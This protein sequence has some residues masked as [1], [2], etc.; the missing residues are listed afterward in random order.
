MYS[1]TVTISPNPSPNR[2]N[3]LLRIAKGALAVVAA[4]WIFLEEWLWDGMLA[5]MAWLGKLPPIRWIESGLAKLPPYAALIA[6]AI[7]VLVLLPFKLFAFWL[8]ARGYH[9]LGVQVFIVAKIIGTAL[10]ARIFA[11]TKDAL[12]RIIWFA[13]LYTWFITWK[14]KLYAY[15]RGLATYRLIVQW[16]SRLRARWL[17][18]RART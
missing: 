4:L 10:L 11:L 7:P 2:E 1:P 8:M 13:K 15:V 12:M 14:A 3:I 16:K 6:F 5:A 17:A 18:W 9:L